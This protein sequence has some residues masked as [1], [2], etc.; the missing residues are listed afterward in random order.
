M[1]DYRDLMK[2]LDRNENATLYKLENDIFDT[3]ALVYNEGTPQ[4]EVLVLTDMQ[5]A[6]PTCLDDID[7]YDWVRAEEVD[8]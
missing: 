2:E 5:G 3:V 6:Y 7:G 1:M 8:W 4:E